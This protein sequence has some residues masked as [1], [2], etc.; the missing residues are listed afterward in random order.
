[1][2]LVTQGKR[3]EE[4]RITDRGVPA[5]T[6]V[7]QGFSKETA[8]K[9]SQKV[10]AETEA[11]LDRFGKIPFVPEREAGLSADDLS[12]VS[13]ALGELDRIAGGT[14]SVLGEVDDLRVRAL[15]LLGRGHEAWVR[16]D[17]LYGL[18]PKVP[19]KVL[20]AVACYADQRW[21]AALLLLEELSRAPGT[22]TRSPEVHYYLGAVYYQF[23]RT[24]EAERSWQSYLALVE[25]SPQPWQ[26]Q[27]IAQTR[28]NLGY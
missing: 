19:H 12:K 20:L 22:D 25:G 24:E 10:R 16:A 21:D 23:G 17:E 18:Q 4:G 28:A 1:M 26:A 14:N 8:A 27:F 15:I 11:V 13:D 5:K 9:L 6:Q 7:R 3:W 2:V